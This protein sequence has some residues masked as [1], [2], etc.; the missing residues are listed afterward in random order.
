MNITLDVLKN[1]PEVIL[2]LTNIWHE[3]IGEIWFPELSNDYFRKKLEEFITDDTMPFT[4]VAY[5]KNNPIGMCVLRKVKSSERKIIDSYGS[6]NTQYNSSG[7]L[8]PI[9]VDLKYQGKGIGKL[10]INAV[11]QRANELSLKKIYLIAFDKTIPNYYASFGFK[12]IGS[13]TAKG[14]QGVVMEMII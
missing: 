1:E 12:E 9:M 5:N 13:T 3:T 10:L 8:G 6:N 14:H 7:W 4:L 11:K 2:K